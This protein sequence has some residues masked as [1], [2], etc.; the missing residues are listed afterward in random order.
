VNIHGLLKNQMV[1]NQLEEVELYL[2]QLEEMFKNKEFNNS[3]FFCVI[4]YI[5]D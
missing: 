3:L 4:I 2:F 5:G 1:M